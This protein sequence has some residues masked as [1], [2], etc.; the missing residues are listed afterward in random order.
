V[1]VLRGGFGVSRGQQAVK[2]SQRIG[3][4]KQPILSNVVGKS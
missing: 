3:R 2:V 1:P 4:R